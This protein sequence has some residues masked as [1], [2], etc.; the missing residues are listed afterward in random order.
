M[1]TK[2]QTASKQKPAAKQKTALKPEHKNQNLLLLILTISFTATSMLAASQ[3]ILVNILVNVI[4]PIAIMVFCKLVFFERL[5]LTTLT[6]LRIAIVFSV[7]NIL[8]RQLFV[9]LVL[10]FL[11]INILEATLTDIFRY[12]R[13]LN[14]IT[15][16]ALAASVYFLRGSWIDL[17]NLSDLG[18][19]AKYMHI[20][21]FHA[22]TATGT[23]C[24]IIAYT[25]WNWVFVTNEFSSSVSKLHVGILASPILG[26]LATWNPGYWLTFRASSL[27]F[28]GCLQIAEKEYVEENLK[29]SKFSAFVEGT[30]KTGVQAVLMVINLALIA[31]ACFVK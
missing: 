9:N 15:G 3:P 29:S 17:T 11:A 19:F 4:L 21:E 5:K 7:F 20:Y 13:Y 26:C 10:I 18:F 1:A 6:L 8:D 31:V 16:L 25:I 24:W 2:T 23:I 12:K 27:A 22:A 30:K 28:G 14:G